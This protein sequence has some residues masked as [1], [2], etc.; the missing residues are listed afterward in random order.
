MTMDVEQARKTLLA[1]GLD[2]ATVGRPNAKKALGVTH[3]AAQKILEAIRG[4][5]GVVTTPTKKEPDVL[6]E[7]HEQ[8]DDTWV[9]SMP[10]TEIDSLEKLIAHCKIDLSVWEVERWICNKWDVAMCPPPVRDEKGW[11]RTSDKTRRVQLFQVKA[12]LV[13]KSSKKFKGPQGHAEFLRELREIVKEDA[14][15]F[16]SSPAQGSFAAVDPSHHEIACVACSD[17]HLT[18]TVRPDDANGVNVF[19]TVIAAN[20][21]W[22]HS[23]KVRNILGRHMNLYTI[24]MIWSPLLGDVINGSIHEEFLATNELTDVAA[25]ILGSRLIYMFYQE[26]KGLGLPIEIDAVHGNHARTTP[27]VPTKRQARTNLDWQL[28]EILADRFRGDDQIKLDITTSQIGT[29]KIFGWNYVFEHGID[30][31]N[32]KEED[33]EDRVRALLDDPTFR[34]A[35]GYKGASFDQIVIGNMHKPKFLERTIVNGSY[36][37]QNELGMSWRLKP[38]RAQQLMWG[39]SAKHVRTWQY[40]LDL[41]HVKTERINNPFAE[42]ASWFMRKHGR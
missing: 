10:R 41:T 15:R 8:T 18:E 13:K 42:Y 5:A 1:A 9:I 22:E 4:T 17:V 37:G 40:Q 38:I 2:P 7:S 6:A 25:V 33:F 23:Q 24:D 29:R 14:F 19:N 31:R 26:L 21:L 39:S 16:D 20:R 27:K 34:E 30:V 36:T 11:N 3:Y 28:Y 32:G 12:F 35:T